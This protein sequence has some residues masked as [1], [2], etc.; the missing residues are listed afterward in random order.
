MPSSGAAHW[1]PTRYFKCFIWL[2]S[3][4]I[5]FLIAWLHLSEG[6]MCQVWKKSEKIAGFFLTKIGPKPVGL[7]FEPGGDAPWRGDL[8]CDP[9]HEPTTWPE[10]EKQ[11]LKTPDYGAYTSTTPKIVT[12]FD[13]V[14]EGIF[15]GYSGWNPVFWLK[16]RSRTDLAIWGF[17]GR[18]WGW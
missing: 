1:F 6:P 10:L 11:V 13:F 17:C 15:W 18:T 5:F 8:P 9:R 2:N 7:F 12:N 3:L 14:F 16:N 4:A